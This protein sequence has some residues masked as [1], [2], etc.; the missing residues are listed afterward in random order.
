MRCSATASRIAAGSTSR[1]TTVV[2]PCPQPGERPTGAG[3]VEQRHHGQ[4]HGVGAE[5]PRPGHAR[6]LAAVVGVAEHDALGQPGGAR[7]VHQE[8]QVVGP[9][10]DA[11]VDG[12]VARTPSRRRRASDRGLRSRRPRRCPGRLDGFEMWPT[13]SSPTTIAA[14]PQSSMMWRISGAASRQLT[15]T[16][17]APS[18]AR[19]KTTSKNSSPFFSTNA[20][21]SPNPMPACAN[22]CAAR[23]DRASSS[24]NVMV[25]SPTTR[26]GASGRLPAVH[27]DDVGE[28]GDP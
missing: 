2:A 3:H 28:A 20:T 8:H 1:S 5:L 19:P 10:G 25:R 23:L 22:A 18:L 26:A 4:A 24:P 15:G 16:P 21:R 7:R 17:T 27:A 11:G 9:G 12:R 13:N 14:A 6:G